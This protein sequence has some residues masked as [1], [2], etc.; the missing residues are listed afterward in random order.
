MVT[1]AARP[2][3]GDTQVTS[4]IDV[5]ID[6][7]ARSTAS[8]PIRTPPTSSLKLWNQ[9]LPVYVLC[10]VGQVFW[11]MFAGNSKLLGFPIGPDRLLFGLG[12]VLMLL[13]P[14][15]LRQQKLRLRPVHVAGVAVAFI[16]AGSAFANGTFDKTGFY[17]WL[18]RLTIP[19]L[20]FVLAPIVFR[21][22]VR[23]DLLLRVLVVIGLY[24]GLT[25]IFEVIGPHALV[26]PRFIMD[27]NVGIQFGRARG[28]FTESEADG[29]AMVQCAFAAAFAAT[30]LP[31]RWKQVSV[32]TVGA[33]SIGVLL[34][35]TRSVWIGSALGVAVVC[36]LTPAL[37]KFLLPLAICFGLV[38][39]VVL[40][41]APTVRS[42]ASSQAGATRSVWDRENT[43]TAA[44]RI[45]ERHP[46]TG[47]GWVRFVDVSEQWVRQAHGYP[48]T[49][50]NIEVHNVALGRAAE[51]GLPAAALWV[52]SV[53]AGPCLVFF[54][55]RPPGD[56]AGWAI[57][58][59]GGTCCWLVA[60]NLSPV[61]YPLPNL[62]VWLMS[63]IALIPFLT[64]PL[65][66]VETAPGLSADARHT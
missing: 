28:P 50:I 54:R 59:M 32:L 29:L 61:P 45:I 10:F 13:D 3:A 51:L 4:T 57:V 21:T 1:G 24:L 62:L 26:Y 48:I 7:T 16:A 37:R 25:A 30:R 39:G 19:L 2:S 35:L 52:F 14:V 12:V 47:V 58:S 8:G 44:L 46:L 9:D 20:M 11:N 55:R 63:G 49:N 22:A 33:C 36:L 5:A 17:A 40:A 6:R 15:A 34:T 53:L 65:S 23:R 27:P 56:L 31:G 38:I 18:D 64:R 41:V 42:D 66:S 60:I 43:D